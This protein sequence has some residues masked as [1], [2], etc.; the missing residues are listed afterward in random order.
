[1]L[2]RV[3]AKGTKELNLVAGADSVDIGVGTAVSARLASEVVL[4]DLLALGRHVAA[5]V[6]ADVGPVAADL[7]TIDFE[8]AE[9]VVAAHSDCQSQDGSGGLH[10]EVVLR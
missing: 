6:L 4:K 3:H 8:S 2:N 7:L 5:S 1:M 10:G 9:G